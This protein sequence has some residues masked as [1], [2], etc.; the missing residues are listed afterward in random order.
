MQLLNRRGSSDAADGRKRLL[1]VVAEE[2]DS[3]SLACVR[4][5]AAKLPAVVA[6]FLPTQTPARRTVEHRQPV[7]RPRQG[8]VQQP[9]LFGQRLDVRR[10]PLEIDNEHVVEL[11][12]FGSVDAGDDDRGFRHLVQLVGDR[13]GRARRCRASR[14]R[15]RSSRHASNAGGRAMPPPVPA[16]ASR[17]RRRRARGTDGDRRRSLRRARRSPPATGRRPGRRRASE[18]G[19][20]CRLREA[21]PRRSAP[22]RLFDRGRQYDATASSSS[23]AASRQARSQRQGLELGRDHLA[24]QVRERSS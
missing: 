2:L 23:A 13:L 21:A 17:R 18:D 3:V 1:D 19:A 20:G 10:R 12:A 14:A 16:S 5:H 15:S 7:P 24:Q 11:E 9:R 8:H 6:A 4:R 22:P